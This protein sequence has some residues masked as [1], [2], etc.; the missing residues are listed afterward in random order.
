MFGT[1]RKAG[2]CYKKIVVIMCAGGVGVHGGYSQ[3]C[4]FIACHV[5][6]GLLQVQRICSG[7]Q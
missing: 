1:G 2:V 7:E 4:G 3:G 6:F 5:F